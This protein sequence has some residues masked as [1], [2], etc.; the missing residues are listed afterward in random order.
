MSRL[1]LIRNFARFSAQIRKGRKVVSAASEKCCE[2]KESGAEKYS[3]Q[4][5]L[6]FILPS[7]WNGKEIRFGIR[8][9]LDNGITRNKRGE[10]GRRVIISAFLH[11]APFNPEGERNERTNE[12]T[13]GM[14]TFPIVRLPCH[15]RRRRRRRVSATAALRGACCVPCHSC[16]RSGVESDCGMG[17]LR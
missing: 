12:R 16:G 11:S 6:R 17:Q 14:E 8:P 3:V 13:N 1:R 10:S 7:L 4:I 15:P 9:R 5:N 2:K